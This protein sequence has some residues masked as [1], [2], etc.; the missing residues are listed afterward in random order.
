MRVFRGALVLAAC[1]LV[2]SAAGSAT[3]SAA[4]PRVAGD[5]SLQY[6]RWQSPT[7]RIRCDYRDQVGVG[8]VQ[9]DRGWGMFLRSFAGVSFGY[10]YSYPGPG[11]TL[12]YGQTWRASSFRCLSQS[13]GMKCWST[14]TGHGFL[15]S[16]ETRIRTG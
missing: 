5:A 15:I 1:I 7:G 14:L 6:D 13:T 2:V 16:R 8:C 12:Y 10:P 4:S 3:W 9:L 11:R